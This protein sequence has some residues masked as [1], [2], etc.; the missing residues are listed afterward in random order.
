MRLASRCRRLGAACMATSAKANAIPSV[1]CGFKLMGVEI[2]AQIERD[3]QRASVAADA[4]VLVAQPRANRGGHHPDQ[5]WYAK[6]AFDVAAAAPRLLRQRPSPQDRRGGRIRF[7]GACESG[8]ADHYELDAYL[9]ES[10]LRSL[11]ASRRLIAA[12]EELLH[13]RGRTSRIPRG[14]MAN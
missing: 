9:V 10:S 11:R 4:G 1:P 6:G 13:D 3:R 5:R 14:T 8:L 7:V 2:G 12:T